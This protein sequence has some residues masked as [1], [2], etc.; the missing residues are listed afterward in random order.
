[1]P[2]FISSYGLGVCMG[3]TTGETF[4]ITITA[5]ATHFQACEGALS[6]T[7]VILDAAASVVLPN[8]RYLLRGLLDIQKA[9]DVA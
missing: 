5:T 3:T 6:K 4:S 2:T 8:E 9:A 7:P 1:M